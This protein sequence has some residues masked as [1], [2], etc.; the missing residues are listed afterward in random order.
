ME[1]N[2]QREY[3]TEEDEYHSARKEAI[4]VDLVRR[5]RSVCANLSEEEFSK[6]VDTMTEQKLRS[7]RKPF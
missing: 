6:L 1:S 5:L 7:E 4:R 2:R 3:A